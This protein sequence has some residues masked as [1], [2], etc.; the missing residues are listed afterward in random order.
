MAHLTRSTSGA[1]AF[2]LAALALVSCSSSSSSGTE[3]PAPT[4]VGAV[5]T[6]PAPVSTSAGSIPVIAEQKNLAVPNHS[7]DTMTVGVRSLTID[8]NGTT[9]TLRLVFTPQFASKPGQTV[10]LGDLAPGTYV[11]PSLLDRIHLERYDVIGA[12]DGRG[13]LESPVGT[14]ASNGVPF[15]AW[16]VFAAPR[17]PVSTLEVSV[18]DAWPPFPNVPVQR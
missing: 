4:S 10:T 6:S 11:L 9:M 1:A 3:P 14:G 13:F 7:G 16:F 18:L 5:A 15:E 8:P 2:L 17:D 12:A